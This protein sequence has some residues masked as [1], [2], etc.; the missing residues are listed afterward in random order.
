M[1][2][3]HVLVQNNNRAGWLTLNRPKA[4]NALNGE[5]FSLMSKALER[6]QQDPR[7]YGVVLDAVGEKVFCAGGDIRA[8][9]ELAL[10]DAQAAC[11]FLAREYRYNWQ[12]EQFTKPH[13]ALLNGMVLGGGAGISLYGPHQVAGEKFSLAMP[14]TSIG[15]VPDVGGSWFLGH[16]P[17]SVGLYLSLTG[18]AINRADAYKL[19]LVSHVIDARHFDEIRTAMSE[20]EPIDAVLDGLH[21]DPG[22]GELQGVHSWIETIFSA[23]SLKEIF[24]RAK[25]VEERSKGWSRALLDELQQKSPTSLHLAHQLWKR[26]RHSDLQQALENEYSVVCNLVRGK[27]FKE[28]VRALLVDKDKN[29]QWSPKTI[30]L[31][32]KREVQ[33]TLE[34]KWG[35]L[36]LVT[37]AQS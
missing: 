23:S 21:T 25:A 32:T 28:G 31:V 12:L 27:D 14:E 6:W 10:G 29:P 3:K 11:D 35:T 26:G 22:E 36:G 19:G 8:V 37:A 9:Y 7:I 34:N 24:E 4:L 18:R 1:S 2:E 15:F 16:L 17:H 20:G 33:A 5:M 30:D 13:V